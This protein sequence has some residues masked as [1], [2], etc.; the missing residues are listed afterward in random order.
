MPEPL[1]P[2]MTAISH[3]LQP[4]VDDLIKLKGPMKIPTFKK[5]EG[6]MIQVCLLTLV[7]DTGATHK[8]GGFASH[9]EKYFYSWCLAKDTNIANL[10]RGPVRE[11]QNTREKGFQWK[12]ASKRQQTV[13][14][15]ESGV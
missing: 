12:N 3:L 9:S 5:P 8:V 6:R 7:G 4:L 15:R 2:N 1:A 14:L 10:Q 11:S 13:L